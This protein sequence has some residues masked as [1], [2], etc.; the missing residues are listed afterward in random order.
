M[1]IDTQINQSVPIPCVNHRSTTNHVAIPKIDQHSVNNQR[2]NCSQKST[3]QLAISFPFFFNNPSEDKSLGS[4]FHPIFP[5]KT[6][7]N[8]KSGRSTCSESGVNCAVYNPPSLP[9]RVATLQGPFRIWAK[10]EMGV[11]CNHKMLQKSQR[12]TKNRSFLQKQHFFPEQKN[13]KEHRKACSSGPKT[14]TEVTC[15]SRSQTTRLQLHHR[16]RSPGTWHVV[17][18]S[19]RYSKTSP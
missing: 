1:Q 11:E 7:K 9:K 8:I 12:K 5:A 15:K 16:L 13:Q 17:Q 10:K 18:G 14:A 6:A 19:N 2:F 4:V 3:P